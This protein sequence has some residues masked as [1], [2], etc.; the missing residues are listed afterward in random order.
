MK[1]ILYIFIFSLSTNLFSQ[2]LSLL[3]KFNDCILPIGASLQ[4]TSGTEQFS[5]APNTDD[6]T[7][8]SNCA[9]IYNS[10]D[11]K[12]PVK[13]KFSYKS[14]S[15]EL[16][17]GQTYYTSFYLKFTNPRNGVIRVLEKGTSL[18]MSLNA[19]SFNG[20]VT[21]NL[22]SPSIGDK[23]VYYVVEYESVGNDA[24]TQIII[25]DFFVGHANDV[26]AKSIDLVL[27]QDCKSGVGI[28]TFVPINN[29]CISNLQYTYWYHYTATESGLVEVKVNADYNV[30]ANVF[31]G[32]CSALIQLACDDDDEF[33]FTG[34]QMEI[35]VQSGKTYYVRLSQKTNSY[36]KPIGTH[37]VSVHKKSN[38]KIIPVHDLCSSKQNINI[39]GSC[40]NGTNLNARTEGPA[41]SYNT[42]S[43]SDIWYSF[44]PTSTKPL[45]IISHSNFAEV[46]TLYTGTCAALQEVKVEDLG[47]HLI[48]ENPKIGTEYIL[49]VS[50]YFAT[51]EGNLCVEVIEK[52]ATI[53]ANDNCATPQKISLNQSCQKTQ[54][55]GGTK[56]SIKPSCVVYNAADLWYSFNTGAENNIALLIDAGFSYSWALYTGTCANLNEVYCGDSQ[57]PCDGPIKVNGLIPNTTYLLQIV[58][59]SNLIKVN[60]GEICVR[61]DELSKTS[62]FTPLNLSLS[63]ECLHGVLT[64]VSYNTAGG[65]GKINYYGPSATDVFFNGSVIEAFIEDESKC[66][67]IKSTVANCPIPA[68]CRNSSLDID[69]L[70]QCLSDSVGR[71]T[72]EMRLTIN[73]KG[74]SGIYYFYGNKNGDVLRH[75]DLYKIILIDSDSCFVIEEGRIY[76]PP[77]DCSKSAMKVNVQY[78][79]IDT[80]LKAR[81]N[82]AVTGSIGNYTITGN[83]NLELL[84]Q[85]TSYLVTSKDEA[86]CEATSSGKINC[87]FDS[88][89]YSR[90]ALDVKFECLINPINGQKTGKAKLIVTGTSKAGGLTYIGNKNGDILNHQDNYSV[91]LR[92]AF[93]CG[94]VKS[95]QINCAIVA[96]DDWASDINCTVYPNPTDENS[97]LKFNLVKSEDIKITVSTIDGKYIYQSKKKYPTGISSIELQSKNYRNGIYIITLESQSGTKELK[98]IKQ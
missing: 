27:D 33:G 10:T 89:A 57:D 49:Q 32:T 63:T 53:P 96:N 9:L 95:G 58:A 79:C 25:D 86:G 97:I 4:L 90:V 44:R 16:I 82:I 85:G 59:N 26:C 51:L 62:N 41:P 75:G 61:V 12:N 80:L 20:L 71:N 67:D 7:T 54:I 11:R 6:V 87:D 36:G 2:K 28:P 19:S 14:N 18:V 40:I 98:L 38:P 39:N 68:K 45:E 34:E 43:K 78:D 65:K 5:I 50:G 31:E 46:M 64:R 42:R 83:K 81:L 84:D 3:E 24:G 30:V 21:S 23:G 55:F 69:L 56:S 70:T 13:R 52:S 60:E 47:N 37:C 66:R 29:A 93:G 48:F 76:C 8:N 91:E 15:F 92:D 77:F 73:G 74:G 1:K 72:G 35:N 17:A 22:F 94:I 88:C